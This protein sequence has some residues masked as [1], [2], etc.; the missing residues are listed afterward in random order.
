[1]FSDHVTLFTAG[2]LGW[3]VRREST[4]LSDTIFEGR[5]ARYHGAFTATNYDIRSKEDYYITRYFY[6]STS[7][8]VSV[9]YKYVYCGTETSDHCWLY[10]DD[11]L[12]DRSNGRLP[13]RL[14][15]TDSLLRKKFKKCTRNDW[16]YNEMGPFVIDTVPSGRLFKIELNLEMNYGNDH[17]AITDLTVACQSLDATFNAMENQQKSGQNTADGI[18]AQR[19]AVQLTV[20][21]KT[22]WNVAAMV[23]VLAV[24]AVCIWFYVESSLHDKDKALSGSSWWRRCKKERRGQFLPDED[25]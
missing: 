21:S 4:A 25:F 12:V 6:C 8:K 10:L 17:L 7:S 11:V 23:A 14:E 22:T 24:N 15:W 5:I 3:A 19:E 20:D 2:F 16:T 18:A 13:G 1:M 9:R